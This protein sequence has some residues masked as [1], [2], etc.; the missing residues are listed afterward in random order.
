MI[1]IILFLVLFIVVVLFSFYKFYFLRDPARKV[2]IG[3]ENIVSPADGKIIMVKKFDKDKVDIDKRFLGKVKALTKDVADK[4]F[5]VSIF[6]NFFDVHV[7][8]APISGIV[9]YVKHSKGRFINAERLAA[10]FEN[11]NVQTLFQDRN[12][13]LKVIQIAGMV[14]RRIVPFIKEKE[15][16]I[17]GQKIGI[18][19][20]GSQVTLILPANVKIN[21]HEEQ[22]VF[23]GETVIATR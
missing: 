23:A 16:V 14:A 18:I 8:R 9:K 6:M 1:G 20:L 7:N 5:L 21:V 2:P 4:G 11:E 13:K 3:G 17:K 19:K 12:F 15:K 10:T 22:K